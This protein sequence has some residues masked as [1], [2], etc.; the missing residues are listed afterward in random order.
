MV[1][2]FDHVP[3]SFSTLSYLGVMS[4]GITV[5][6]APAIAWRLRRDDPPLAGTL[7][8]L[9]ITVAYAF[10]VTSLVEIGENER[11]RFDFGPTS[12]DRCNGSCSGM[13][14]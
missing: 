5:L 3:P 9:W 7:I 1:A 6:G 11:F 14:A 8:F 12:F 4:F 2:F 13:L 10:A